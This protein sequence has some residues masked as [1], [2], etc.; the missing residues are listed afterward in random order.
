MA[1]TLGGVAAA[2]ACAPGADACLIVNSTMDTDARDGVLTLREALLV[3]NGSLDAASLSPA[4]SLQVRTVGALG[5]GGAVHIV[6]DPAVFCATCEATIVLQQPPLL[7]EPDSYTGGLALALPPILGEPDAATPPLLGEPD[8]ATPPLLGEPDA[9]APPIL[10]EPDSARTRW[11]LGMSVVGGQLVPARVVIDGSALGAD[12]VG[13]RVQ[14][15][16]AVQGITLRNFA[17]RALEIDAQIA[18][19]LLLGSDNDGV[20]DAAEGLVFLDNGADVVILPAQ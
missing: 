17:G 3:Q 4:E 20:N 2:T 18:P 13:L 9:V 10:G 5:L 14:A 11:L 19:D 8:A 1:I 16:G 12:Y 15:R 6:F 7:G